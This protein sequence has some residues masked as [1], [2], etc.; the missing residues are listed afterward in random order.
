LNSCSPVI[1]ATNEP[2]SDRTLLPLRSRESA[3]AD[4]RMFTEFPP[5]YRQIP[6]S[7]TAD[8]A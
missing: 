8:A 6:D 5:Q 3:N 2:R 1:R 4:E 7:Q